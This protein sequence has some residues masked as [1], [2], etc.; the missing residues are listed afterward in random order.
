MMPF[1]GGDNMAEVAFKGVKRLL[2]PTD[3]IERQIHNLE[4]VGEANY[5]VGISSPKHDPIKRGIEAEDR[6]ANEM[7]KVIAEKR[8]QKALGFVTVDE[9]FNYASI[10]GAPRLVPGVTQRRKEVEKFVNGWHPILLAH[11]KE[12]DALPTA[13]LEQRIDKMVK[14][15]RGLVA[16]KMKW[17]GRA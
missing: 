2:D 16:N 13:T 6:Y 5:R 9:W 4:S 17:R 12:L 8:R 14:N 10:I 7:R 11:V 3:W 1:A 15:V